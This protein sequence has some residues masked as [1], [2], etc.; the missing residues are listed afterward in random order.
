MKVL[1]KNVFITKMLKNDA[2]L[3]LERSVLTDLKSC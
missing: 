1:I 3:Q 2:V